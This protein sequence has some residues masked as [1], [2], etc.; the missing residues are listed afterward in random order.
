MV[1]DLG[2]ISLSPTWNRVD[3]GNKRKQQ[4]LHMTKVNWDWTIELVGGRLDPL[5]CSCSHWAL[6]TQVVSVLIRKPVSPPRSSGSR[7]ADGQM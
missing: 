7:G 5:T 4:D 2:V 3:V 1:L 6:T